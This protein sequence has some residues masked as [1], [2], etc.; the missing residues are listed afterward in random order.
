[1]TGRQIIPYLIPCAGVIHFGFALSYWGML[2][3]VVASPAAW[4][5][6]PLEWVAEVVLIPMGNALILFSGFSISQWLVHSRRGI[7]NFATLITVIFAAVAFTF[8]ANHTSAQVHC[9]G[10]PGT[11]H[12]YA[13]WWLY[14][15]C[16]PVSA[17]CR[18]CV[19]SLAPLL[20]AQ[21]LFSCP[22]EHQRGVAT[23][24]PEDT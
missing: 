9:F 23:R 4:F 7:A 18:G 21:V 15:E 5:D 1:M 17:L 24:S 19:A 14:S 11:N 13:T 22:I 3:F 20:A 6:C 10:P 12:F 8:N 2:V 16:P